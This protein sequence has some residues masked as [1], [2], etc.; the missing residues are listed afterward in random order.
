LA[1]T[2]NAYH[3]VDMHY[4]FKSLRVGDMFMLNGNLMVKRSTKTAW[5]IQYERLFYIGQKERC[6]I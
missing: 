2:C 1:I 5:N 4:E 6:T 3:E